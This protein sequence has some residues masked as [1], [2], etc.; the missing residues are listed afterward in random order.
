MS[1]P[2]KLIYGVVDERGLYWN[3][4]TR[5]LDYRKFKK[6]K[7]DYGVSC[8]TCVSLYLQAIGCLAYGK[9]FTHT[10][11]TGKPKKTKAKALIGYK[12]LKNGTL[13]GYVG[14]KVADLPKK[15]KVD[16]AVFV[17]ESDIGVYTKLA[18]GWCVLSCNKQ[19]KQT[20]KKMVHRA[21]S[22]QYTR[23]VLFV[24]LPDSVKEK[25][26]TYTGRLK[27]DVIRKGDKKPVRIKLIQKFLEWAGFWK[28]GFTGKFDLALENALKKFQKKVGIEADG[29][30]GKDT[31]TKAKSYKI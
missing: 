6:G 11:R 30:W 10:H 22:Y 8:G 19:G 31:Y 16:G 13:S 2:W 27:P 4:A 17:Y 29:V 25:K 12:N 20:K 21:G 14:K 28:G 1:V 3:T 23:E 5:T 9:Q 18:S 7:K 15:Y 24:F 26:Y